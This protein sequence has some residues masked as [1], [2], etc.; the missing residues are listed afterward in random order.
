MRQVRVWLAILICK[1]VRFG[2]RVLGRGG[3]TIPGKFA[4]RVCPDLL[5]VLGRQVTTVI[6]T[7][8]NGKTTSARMLEQCFKNG[9]IPAFSNRSGANLLPGITAEF[10]AHAS[11]SGKMRLHYAVI[12]CDEAAFKHVSKYVDAKVI[13]VTNVFRDQLDRF[14]EITHTL[15][16]IQTGIQNS[17]NATV[18]LNADCALLLTMMEG[19]SNPVHYYGVDAPLFE[20]SSED[21]LESTRCACG[22]EYVYDYRTYGHLGAYRCP[23]CDNA[24]P[25]L[26]VAV[27]GILEETPDTSK[28]AVRV[29][30]E[31]HEVTI[32][33]PGAYNIYNAAGVIA[34]SEVMNLGMAVT[35]A[36]LGEFRGGFGRMERFSLGDVT[37]RMI[38]VKNPIGCSQA[39][40][41]LAGQTEPFLLVMCLNDRPGDGADVS[42][43]W[44]VDTSVFAGL[45]DRLTGVLCGGMR[46][47][48]LAVW[49]KYAGVPLEKISVELDFDRLVD[50]VGQAKVPVYVMPTYTAMM[51]VRERIAK[52][53]GLGRFW[54]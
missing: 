32:N 3:T 7:G 38:L 10:A 16:S 21:I 46:G 22:A 26:D 42:W 14:G 49:M 20:V 23:N 18:C 47:D 39:L 33:L 5:G 31:Q 43:L 50:V 19:L 6:I 8:T 52:R 9:A 1:M 41:Y 28:I 45:G 53:Y 13:L 48:E 40:R 51:D 2:L 35:G 15:T 29:G 4:L 24:R 37:V 11:L 54:E 27:T 30:G 36:A 25:V 44:D 12:E 17:P 34:V